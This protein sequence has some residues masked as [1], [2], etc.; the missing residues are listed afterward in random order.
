MHG[1]EFGVVALTGLALVAGAA[2]RLFSRRVKFPY[3]IGMLLFG[4]VLG[5]WVR[6][7]D[8]HSPVW[9]L[10]AH[11][12]D[13]APD[14]IIFVFLPALVFESAF[15][16]D[17][18]KFRKNLGAVALYAGPVLVVAT[19]LT[20]GLLLLL[21][22]STWHWSLVASLVFGALISATDPVAVVAIFSELGVAKR[23]GVLVEGESML[24]DGTSIVVYSLLIQLLTGDLAEFS[25]LDALL[26]FA[27]VVVGGIAVGVVLAY[28]ISRWIARM[29]NDPLSEITLTLVLAYACMVIA[30]GFLHVSGVMAVVTAGL[31][32][33]ATGKR[34]IS[35]EASGF[36]HR[37][38]HLLGYIANT[39]IF[40]LV[41]LLIARQLGRASAW[42]F[43]II[44][45]TYVGVMLVR[46]VTTFLAQPI[47]T[48]LS[49]GVDAKDSAVITWGGLRGAVSLALALLVARNEA[50]DETLR[51]Q[52]L[53]LTAGVVL[54]TIL[55]NGSTMSQLLARFGFD[56]PPL[57]E[58]LSLVNAR[59]LVL[60]EVEHRLD[61]LSHSR[62][63][64]TVDWSLVKRRLHGRRQ[65]I[66][67]EQTELQTALARAP[68]RDRVA[69]YFGQVLDLEVGAYWDAFAAGTLTDQAVKVLDADVTR[70]RNR[71]A[72]GDVTPQSSR[73]EG[74]VG[75]AFNLRKS[76]MGFEQV[77]MRHDLWRAEGIAAERVLGNLHV[78]Q[79]CDAAI[80]EQVQS[81][82]QNY[83]RDSKARLEDLRTNLPEMAAAIETRLAQRIELNLERDQLHE[84]EHRGVLD[85]ARVQ[86]ELEQV[87][88]RMSELRRLA[89]RIEIPETA[90]LVARTRLFCELNPTE[91]EAVAELTEEMLLPPGERL[92][93]Q[94][95]PGEALY[96]IARGALQIVVQVDSSEL[97]VDV[98]GGGDVVGEMALLTG[99]PRTASAVA[100]TSVT[101][102]KIDRGRFE[103]LAQR[104]PGL[105][106]QIWRAFSERVFDNHLRDNE[107]YVHLGHSERIA[108]FRAGRFHR[109][110]AG[111]KVTAALADRAVFLVYGSVRGPRAELASVALVPTVEGEVFEARAPTVLC[112]LPEPIPHRSER[113]R[114]V[115]VQ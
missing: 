69:G 59:A 64:R 65:D 80:L 30:E 102:G 24:N 44:L 19:V 79:G 77:A 42:D 87:E 60:E 28:A 67:T 25:S 103:Q 17:V 1:I 46:A 20:A 108:W 58:Q 51:N 93:R 110:A 70:Q 106:E 74:L 2:V 114:A 6:E 84:L 35:P 89:R 53:L 63:L 33:S 5:L 72:R 92:F 47:A 82:Y 41:G 97:I 68:Y 98:L 61:E 21:T 52:M 8:G 94:G 16:V 85:H 112:L 71:L 13:F 27:V 90:T 23:L 37:F 101:L 95:D 15:A 88:E 7:P 38:W 54:L 11:G 3:T 83:L 49:E 34:S 26:R 100:L 40:F 36:L 86:S 14:L 99:E 18:N 75:G 32:M 22:A 56:K 78:L 29:F 39:L 76:W 10:V 66:D 45:L 115:S 107:S 62:D 48:R 50:I 104:V 55:V 81:T 31:W 57:F 96:V 43:A 113:A 12:A 105:L 4:V 91:L 9:E 111:E 73:T 109:L